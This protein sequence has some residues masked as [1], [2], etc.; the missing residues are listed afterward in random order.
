MVLAF[1][2]AALTQFRVVT[3]AQIMVIAVLN[4]AVMAFD[5]PCR[6]SVVVELVGKRESI[7]RHRFEFR[8]F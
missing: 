7:E 4:G 3:V 6:Q 2:L 8:R 5:A 1:I